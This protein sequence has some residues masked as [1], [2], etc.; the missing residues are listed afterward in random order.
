MTTPQNILLTGATGAIGPALAAELLLSGAAEHIHVLVRKGTAS[1]SERFHHW[2]N[3]VAACAPLSSTQLDRLHMVAGDVAQERLEFVPPDAEALARRT[4]IIIHAAADTRFLSPSPE[5]W[6]T[7]VEG[8]RRLLEWAQSCPRLR[9]FIF[10]STTCVAGTST[11]RIPEAPV[12][13]PGFSNHYE[14]TKWEAEQLVIASELPVRIARLSVVMGS[15]VTGV[16]HR[17]GA[18][19]QVLRW[20]GRG[21]IPLVPGT[22][23]TR[24]DL[25][26]VETAAR[27]L[28]RAVMHE[29]PIRSIWHI[30]AGERAIPLLE[31]MEFVWSEFHRHPLAHIPDIPEIVDATTYRAA[32]RSAFSQGEAQF[33]LRESIDCFLPGLLLYPRVF[34][35]TKAEAL[36]GGLLPLT[37]WRE[38]L[39]RVLRFIRPQHTRPRARVPAPA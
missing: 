4:E 20:Y 1:A 25:V 16:V 39:G 21:L 31:L 12:A 3:K 15:A 19:H 37:D 11:G 33:R 13:P 34:Q 9:Q 35:T 22:P 8:T 6:N 17:L 5:Q 10:V 29:A 30:A 14:R 7:N 18:L 36:W 38:T 2:V 23:H 32:N 27:L 24:V 26:D 28:A